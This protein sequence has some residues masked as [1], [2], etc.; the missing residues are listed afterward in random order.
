M[1][2]TNVS[3]M[4]TVVECIVFYGE[5]GITRA[6]VPGLHWERDT[7]QVYWDTQLSMW[8]TVLNTRKGKYNDYE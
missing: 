3:V 6:R 5:D 4:G 7:I 1:G 2:V 8:S